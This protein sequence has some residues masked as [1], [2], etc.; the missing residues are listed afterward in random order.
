L[1]I[2]RWI[3]SVLETAGGVAQRVSELQVDPSLIAAAIIAGT[4]TSIVA[5]WI[6]ARNAARVDP[7]K[8]LQKGKYQVL[9]A[10]ENRRRRWMALAAFVVS[11]TCLFFPYSRL[12]FYT[13]YLLMMV[14]GLLLTPALTLLLSKALRPLL[15]L[16]LPA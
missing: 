2:A 11:I 12:V 1:A 15:K 4:G 9:S 13:G 7:V 14:A 6:P 10:G 8:A 16:A 3:S 5:A